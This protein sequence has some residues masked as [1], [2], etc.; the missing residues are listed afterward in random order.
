MIQSLAE[1]RV[2]TVE[3]LRE[4]RE[5]SPHA[6][7]EADCVAEL[8]ILEEMQRTMRNFDGGATRDSDSGKPDYEGYLSPLV[9]EAFGRYMLKHQVCADGSTRDSDNWQHG[10]PLAVYIKSA[11]RHFFDW[12]AC[13]RGITQRESGGIEDSLCALIFNAQGY[14]H[15]YLKRQSSASDPLVAESFERA[16]QSIAPSAH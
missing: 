8:E 15:E 4:Y 2:R 3:M 1:L 7:G 11:W 6:M 13:H 14:L 10:M 12:W 16:K 9:I 5:V